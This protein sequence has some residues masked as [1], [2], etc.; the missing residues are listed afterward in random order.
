MKITLTGAEFN[1][2]MRVCIPALSKDDERECLR[3]IEI[4]CNGHG[5]GCA[6][7]CD[8]Y[9]L[10]Q[11]RFACQGERGTCMIRPHKTVRNDCTIEITKDGETVSI[12][13]G[14]ETYTRQENATHY[15]CHAH[16]CK[17]AQKNEKRAT[18]AFNPQMLARALKSY[19][20]A[21]G[22]VVF[23]IYGPEQPVVL[24]AGGKFR[25]PCGLVLPLRLTSASE[26]PEFWEMEE[27]Q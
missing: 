26:E 18:I 5:E 27:K 10:A 16:I 11:T 9:T 1:R 13:D 8:G 20:K 4:Q 12:S 25:D 24:H 7:G 3:C 14:V 19:N 2:I 21:H 22:L 6:T 17:S 23:E 15:I